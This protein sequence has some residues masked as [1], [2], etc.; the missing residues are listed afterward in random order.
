MKPTEASCGLRE[1]RVIITII[2]GYD[3]LYQNRVSYNY[4]IGV[5]CV[6]VRPGES[7]WV[8]ICQNRVSYISVGYVISQ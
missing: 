1:R 4:Q 8:K 7:E 5:S 3:A 6:R 2:S